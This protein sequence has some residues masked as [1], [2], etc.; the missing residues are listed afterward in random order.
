MAKGQ[1]HSAHQ[2]KIIRRY[3]EHF[4]TIQIQKLGEWVSDLYLADS[5]KKADR[6]W[7]SVE[8]ALEK[9]CHDQAWMQKILAD[10]NLEQLAALVNEMA[11]QA[12]A[13]KGRT[14][15]R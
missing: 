13:S 11:N 14:P 12:P 6:I 15:R 1:H 4:D 10:R 2:Q 3:Y 9:S 5:P 8:K 7:K